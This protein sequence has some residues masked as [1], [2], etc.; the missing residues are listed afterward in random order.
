MCDSAAEA[1]AA[2]VEVANDLWLPDVAALVSGPDGT[3]LRASEQAAELAGEAF[4]EELVG[5]RLTELLVPDG[6]AWRLRSRGPSVSLVRTAVWPHAEDE[7]LLVTVLLDVSDLA[8]APAR[9]SSDQRVLLTG[10]QRNAGPEDLSLQDV[11]RLA[12]IGT[13]QWEPD[14]NVVLLSPTLRE[15]T[16]HT[17]GTRMS[18]DDYLDAVHP[19]DRAWVRDTWYSFVAHHH[20]VEV[21][22]RYVRPDGTTRI[23]RSHGSATRDSDG[24]VILTGTT[25]DITEQRESVPALRYRATHDVVTGL[26]NRA[27]V[28][29][30]LTT[31]LGRSDAESLAVLACRI[32]NFKRIIT[33]LGHDAGDELLVLLSRRLI[34]GLGAECTVARITGEDEF[35]I[36]CSDLAAAGGLE[37]LTGR[38]SG[39]VR[40]PVPV[41]GHLLHVSAAI[42][43]AI[44][45]DP[46]GDV[47]GLLRFATAAMSQATQ[48]G[49]D[50]VRRAEP[51][52]MASADQQVRVEGQLREAVHHDG[53]RLHYQPV[54]AADGSII[55][56]EALV[57]WP[58]P[59]RGLLTPGA[60]LPVAERGGLLRELDQWVLRTA[61]RDAARWPRPHG[62]P[63]NIAVNLTGL[64]PG[65][66]AFGDVVAEAV[67]EA[68][69]DWHRVIFELVETELADP[70]TNTRQGMLRMVRRGAHFAIDDFGTG[71]SSLAR[72]KHLPAQLI[73]IDRQF[74][75][76]IEHDAADRSMTRA[77]IDMGHALD[78]RCIAEGVET[79]GQFHV[80]R[81]LGADAYQGWLFA[82][83]L[84]ESEFATLLGHTP[85]YVPPPST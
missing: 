66:P 80:L 69:I 36:I 18:F 27:A 14:T 70:R 52:L 49:I 59:E 51:A 11:Q 61:L 55:A 1:R 47:E 25:Q 72:L 79:A 13:W 2:L 41:R 73:K 23:F 84:P 21:E 12:R 37:A 63:V 35:L 64:V 3:V 81:D 34:D 71:H 38:V 83:A 65:D 50:Q 40:T 62:T 54:L 17:A 10:A 39:L 26:P 77:I 9:P 20:P 29:E 19:D 60:F 4:P 75:A 24:N 74:V 31:L 78:R 6:A 44:R 42:G 48:H 58:H 68:G 28:H 67:A 15:L 43:A 33:S 32:D 45:D 7:R 8:S 53:L 46:R 85:L 22:H 82:H 30:L 76:G 5:R 16:G 57:R 56:A